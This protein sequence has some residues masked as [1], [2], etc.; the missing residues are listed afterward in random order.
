LADKLRQWAPEAELQQIG[1][2]LKQTVAD[3][4][5]LGS[6]QEKLDRAHQVTALLQ[7]HAT[8]EALQ[9]IL[10]DLHH[11]ANA[12]GVISDAER[13]FMQKTAQILGVPSPV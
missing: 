10:G 12:D 1:E 5:A 8:P 6:R 4:K 13:E 2:V 11:I 3:Y 7:G 9:K